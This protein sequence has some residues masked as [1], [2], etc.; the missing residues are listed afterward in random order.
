MASRLALSIGIT[1]IGEIQV[2]IESGEIAVSLQPL[3]D[4]T[5]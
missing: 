4:K 1:N 5:E 3:T 2:T